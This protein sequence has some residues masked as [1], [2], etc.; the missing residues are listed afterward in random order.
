MVDDTSKGTPTSVGIEGVPSALVADDKAT[1]AL[2]VEALPESKALTAGKGTGPK[3]AFNRF[4]SAKK[5]KF[6]A[7]APQFWPE[8]GR[9]AE[10]VGIDRTTVWL[11]R[12]SDK[13]FDAALTEINQQVCD[14]MEQTL[15]EQGLQPKGFLDRISYLRAHRP[16]LYDRAKTI[17]IETRSMDTTER[18]ARLAVMQSVVDA[19]VVGVVKGRRT[20][21]K[22]SPPQ[23]P[24]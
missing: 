21:A 4:D 13:A 12:K 22:I 24:K 7:L 23:K 11:H 5:A 6:L 15:I 9:L 18:Q 16:E 19:E 8:I 20:Q 17:K 2:G 1:E 3:H 14:R 10:A